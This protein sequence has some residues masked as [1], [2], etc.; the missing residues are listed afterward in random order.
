MGENLGRI[1]AKIETY[2]GSL[3]CRSGENGDTIAKKKK[4][5][6]ACIIYFKNP[7]LTLN[8]TLSEMLVGNQ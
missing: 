2:R 3:M 7:L 8:S 1:F 5:K 6:L 4:K